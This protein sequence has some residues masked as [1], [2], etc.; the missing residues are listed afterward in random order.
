MLSSLIYIPFCPTS[1]R[2]CFQTNGYDPMQYG[3]NTRVKV[4][5]L[6]RCVVTLCPMS[7]P[8]NFAEPQHLWNILLYL[9]GIFLSHPQRYNFS[10]LFCIFLRSSIL[11]NVLNIYS[12]AE[13]K[14]GSLSCFQHKI[15]HIWSELENVF[16][17]R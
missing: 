12:V 8:F 3:S 11:P 15:V 6:Y 2:A 4:F 1:S 5:L 7:C 13:C 17:P 14:L 10:T 9:Y 16:T